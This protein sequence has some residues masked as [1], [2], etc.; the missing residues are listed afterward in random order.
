MSIQLCAARMLL[1]SW[2][3]SQRIS[4]T[5]FTSS[6]LQQNNGIIPLDT[7]F[8]VHMESRIE[9]KCGDEFCKEK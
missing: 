8:R 7:D 6:L 5:G 2:N 9:L 1:Q 4:K 3:F